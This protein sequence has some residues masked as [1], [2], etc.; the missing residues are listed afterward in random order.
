MPNPSTESMRDYIVGKSI[1]TP[2][3]NNITQYRFKGVKFS[4]SWDGM[5][6]DDFITF[7]ELISSIGHEKFVLTTTVGDEYTVVV[8]GTSP[9]KY[10]RRYNNLS[11]K[12]RYKVSL[13][14]IEVPNE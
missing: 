10:D 9:I 6:H 14:L 11:K 5:S 1:T 13:S 12:I 8:D 4:Y 3:G 7:H 2:T